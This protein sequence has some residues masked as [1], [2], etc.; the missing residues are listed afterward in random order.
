MK[1]EELKNVNPEAFA[2]VLKKEHTEYLEDVDLVEQLNADFESVYK[3]MGW[4]DFE[5]RYTGFASQ[6]D[7]ASFKFE[8][9]NFSV[10]DNPLNLEDVYVS[11]ETKVLLESYYGCLKTLKDDFNCVDFGIKFDNGRYCHENTMEIDGVCCEDSEEKSACDLELEAEE[12]LNKTVLPIL[13]EI[14]QKFYRTLEAEYFW[15]NLDN[16]EYVKFLIDYLDESVGTEYD[17]NGEEI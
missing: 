16:D 11:E 3:A 5:I 12:Y 17:E 10:L 4:E 6:G 13:R 1:L 15:H 14:A 9:Q 8:Y 7:G 2:E